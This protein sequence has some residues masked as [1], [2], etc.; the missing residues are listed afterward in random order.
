[1]VTFQIHDSRL[2]TLFSNISDELRCDNDH[3]SES[4]T[5]LPGVLLEAGYDAEVEV[6]QKD[7]KESNKVKILGDEKN[8]IILNAMNL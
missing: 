1:M 3:D 2:L 6:A 7:N 4:T 8:N 5:S